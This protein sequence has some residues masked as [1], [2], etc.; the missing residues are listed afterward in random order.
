MAFDHSMFGERGESRGIIPR[1]VESVFESLEARAANKEVAVVVSF[2]EIYCDRIRDLGTAYLQHGSTAAAATE[3]TS[4]WFVHGN[5]RASFNSTT[6]DSKAASYA[7]ENLGIHEDAKGNVFV[8][9]LSIIPVGTPEEVMTIVQMGF[10]LRA[11]HETKM[12]TVS[13]RSHTVF[14]MHIL[15]KDKGTGETVTGMLNMVDLAGSERLGRSE[16]QGQRLAEALSINSSL[17]ALGKVVMALQNTSGDPT[18]KVHIPYR[19]SKLTRLL[20]NSLGGNSITA[21]LATVHPREADFDESMTTL[22]F[23]ERCKSVSNRPRLNYALVSD[24][25]KDKRIASL[26]KENENLR[27]QLVT[28]R[29]AA[30]MRIVRLML[31][32]GLKGNLLDNGQFQCQDG[33]IIGISTQEAMESDFARKLARQFKHNPDIT[34]ISTGSVTAMYASSIGDKFGSSKQ[35]V[36]QTTHSSELTAAAEQDALASVKRRVREL[37][38]E[39][40]DVREAAQVEQAQLRREIAK[41]RGQAHSAEQESIQKQRAAEFDVTQAKAVADDMLQTVVKDGADLLETQVLRATSRPDALLQAHEYSTHAPNIEQEVEERTFQNVVNLRRTHAEEIELLQHKL[42]HARKAL[43]EALARADEEAKEAAAAAASEQEALE[44]SLH[45]IF[46]Y[47][48]EMSQLVREI[49][50]GDFPIKQKG[51]RHAVSIPTRALPVNPLK[52]TDEGLPAL[53][54][55]LNRRGLPLPQL[56]GRASRQM[57]ASRGIQTQLSDTKFS[58]FETLTSQQLS[59]PGSP[60]QS[61]VELEKADDGGPDHDM[62]RDFDPEVDLSTLHDSQIKPYAVAMQKYLVSGLFDR[63][64]RDAI[65]DLQSNE[66]VKYIKELET[67]VAKYQEQI[68]REAL[69]QTDLRVALESQRRLSKNVGLPMLVASQGAM[70][71]GAMSQGAM[72]STLPSPGRPESPLQLQASFSSTR[73]SLSAR[74][75]RSSVAGRYKKRSIVQLDAAGNIIPPG[76]LGGKRDALE[77]SMRQMSQALSSKRKATQMTAWSALNTSS[78]NVSYL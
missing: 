59:E 66:T 36:G 22:Q 76:G 47:S 70:S 45:S 7:S 15:Q 10:R 67:Q 28:C 24:D 74:G 34:N 41:Y 54:R 73:T 42:A 20:Q 2:L 71:Q 14:T 37:K 9:D 26:I 23:A 11:T 38:R 29:V 52:A 56:L 48:V 75:D 50:S 53:E 62:S 8:K 25:A 35:T 72:T 33:S 46:L 68:R 58:F 69:R 27:E 21:V 78:P 77:S 64:Q 60:S 55:M 49:R 61:E 31:E 32:L 19:D 30:D 6:K 43:D 40:V 57:L 65:R 51:G 16:S 63:I 4:D 13:S 17:S 39:I 18:S 12:N 5:R 3:K 44:Q 1:A